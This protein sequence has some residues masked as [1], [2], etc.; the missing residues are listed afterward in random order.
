MYI[1]TIL[2]F[3]KMHG[4]GNDF[5]VIDGINQ[6]FDASQAPLVL[7]SNRNTGVGFDQLLLVEPSNSEAVDFRYRIFNADGS[8][9]EQCGNGARCFVRF[10]TDKGLTDKR[11]IVVETSSGVI[12]PSLNDNGLIS[13]NMGKPRFAPAEIPFITSSGEAADALTHLVMLGLESVPVS[14]INV[15]NPHAVI[16]VDDVATAPVSRWGEAIE[17]HP[18][19]PDRVNVDF[20]QVI[21]EQHIKLRV[22][23][24]GTGETLA[25]GTGSCAAVVAGIRLGFLDAGVPIKVSLPGGELFIEWQPGDDIMMTGPAQT[26]FEGELQY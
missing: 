20:M 25:C 23:E 10:V 9:V 18:Q 6:T 13:V 8:E 22:F 7:W 21:D 19:F 15:G 4:L 2:K 3:T 26:V 5:M 11:Q 14:C 16:L 12:I 24:R 1:M 17:T